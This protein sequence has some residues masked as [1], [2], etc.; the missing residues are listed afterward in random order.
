MYELDNLSKAQPFLEPNVVTQ[1]LVRPWHQPRTAHYIINGFIIFSLFVSAICI[2]AAI[3]YSF[4]A[5]GKNCN[6]MNI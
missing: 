1:D 2:G 5:T 4:K 6:G 3:G